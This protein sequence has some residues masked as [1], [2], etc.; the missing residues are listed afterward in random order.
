MVVD[1]PF[2]IL[3]RVVVVSSF[4]DSASRRDSRSL[5]R[6]KDPLE[7]MIIMSQ[8]LRPGRGVEKLKC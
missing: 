1:C 8:G 7:S 5:V 6:Q 2:A 4:R 3:L